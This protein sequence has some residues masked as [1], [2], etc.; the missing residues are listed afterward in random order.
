MQIPKST[1]PDNRVPFTLPDTW[2]HGFTSYDMPTSRPLPL[3]RKHGGAFGDNR[4]CGPITPVEQSRQ[5]PW[6]YLKIRKIAFTS[7]PRDPHS[8]SGLCMFVFYQRR[9]EGAL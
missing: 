1:C 9:S 7:V 6:L 5:E 2:V 4:V 8:E 3:F